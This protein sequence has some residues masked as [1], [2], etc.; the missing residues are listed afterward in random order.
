MRSTIID[1]KELLQKA[2]ILKSIDL[3]LCVECKAVRNLC[4]FARCP[5][6]DALD[7]RPKIESGSETFGTDNTFFG[8]APQLFVGSY[9]YPSV[10]SGPMTSF[11]QDSKNAFLAANPA[12]WTNLP[13]EEIINLRFGLLRGKQR[14]FIQKGKNK[15]SNRVMEKLEEISLSVNPVDVEGIYTK[16][17][18]LSI[19][20]NSI[21]QPMGPSAFLTKFDLTDNPKIPKRVD[22]VI[23]DELKAHDQL[24]LLSAEGY[25]VYYLQDIF[26]SGATGLSENAKLVPTRWSITGVDDILGK[27]MISGL[28]D[29]KVINEIEVHH[30]NFL[31]NY[32]TVCLLPGNW[33]FENFETW[34]PGGIFTLTSSTHSTKVD[35]EGFTLAERYK[36]R[37][38]YAS[39]AGGYYASRLAVLE[40]LHK[41]Q[42]QSR[43]VVFREI[44]PENTTPLGVWVVREGMR[45]T[46]R[47]ESL[48]FRSIHELLNWLP[49]VL[50]LDLATYLSKSETLMQRTLSDFF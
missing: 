20:L 46:M 10:Y 8:P 19:Q 18:D 38:S 22:Q 29:F 47:N 9:G 40:F 34:H 37:T 39:T 27:E 41:T 1:P 36:G 45:I 24:Q 48:K 44:T 12:Q 26:S 11:M 5:L 4:G 32:F 33:S 13:L 42:Q 28:R 16:K 6:I 3:S 25:D 23:N 14:T 49:S 7:V 30:G 31:G 15:Q 50:K 21:T 2:P 17:P 35:R 43:I